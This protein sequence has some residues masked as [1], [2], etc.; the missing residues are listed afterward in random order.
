MNKFRALSEP[1]LYVFDVYADGEIVA[2]SNIEEAR[3]FFGE[4][5]EEFWK[6]LGYICESVLVV[7]VGDIIE[8]RGKCKF[9]VNRIRSDSLVGLDLQSKDESE[10]PMITIDI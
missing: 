4:T 3:Q 7:E 10:F 9:Q 1:G 6:K 8:I 2:T 5:W